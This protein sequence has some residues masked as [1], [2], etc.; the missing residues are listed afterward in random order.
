MSSVC[1]HSHHWAGERE[2][3]G[4]VAGTNVRLFR[5]SAANEEDRDHWIR[6]LQESIRDNPFTKIIA[7]KKTALRRRNGQKTYQPP[8]LDESVS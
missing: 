8:V 3:C 4:S 5:L 2:I 7:D 6:C 1:L